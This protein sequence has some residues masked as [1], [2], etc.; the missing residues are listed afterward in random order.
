MRARAH[1]YKFSDLLGYVNYS[2]D[3]IVFFAMADDI[4]VN[5]QFVG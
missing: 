3:I 5:G 4:I 1:G 2:D